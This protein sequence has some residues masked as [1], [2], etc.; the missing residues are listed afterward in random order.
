MNQCRNVR[1]RVYK[2]AET[3]S[4]LSERQVKRMLG[5]KKKRKLSELNERCR[6][7]RKRLKTVFEEL[8]QRILV[9][10]AKISAKNFFS[11]LMIIH[12]H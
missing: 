7:K 6:V 8:K 9:K 4:Q 3:R 10:S 1:L 5:L 12:I 11:I 2:E